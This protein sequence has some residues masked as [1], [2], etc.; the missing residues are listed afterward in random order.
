MAS[1]NCWLI[2]CREPLVQAWLQHV[3]WLVRGVRKVT[4]HRAFPS[5]IGPRRQVYLV[6]Q[7]VHLTTAMRINT[8]PIFMT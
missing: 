5:V 2:Q 3:D 1:P 4:A 8:Y 6:F 7:S